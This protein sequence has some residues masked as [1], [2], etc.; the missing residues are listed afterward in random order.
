VRV[1]RARPGRHKVSQNLRVDDDT[2][3][4]HHIQ[5]AQEVAHAS[6]PF[7]EQIADRAVVPFE[8]LAEIGPG[9]IG[10]EHHHGQPGV[11]RTQVDG[12]PQAV[13]GSRRRH[14]HIG[15]HGIRRLAL[16][17]QSCDLGAQRVGVGHLGD[18]LVARCGQQSRQTLAEQDGVVGEQDPHALILPVRDR[19]LRTRPSR[20]LCA[21]CGPRALRPSTRARP[22]RIREGSGPCYHGAGPSAR[23]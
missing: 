15:D 1:R 23:P 8:E 18:H 2:A 11:R 13:V 12:R 10:A 9:H 14:P 3:R 5:G 21:R 20:A 22:P 4:D 7:L 6:H 16:R 19:P 17:H